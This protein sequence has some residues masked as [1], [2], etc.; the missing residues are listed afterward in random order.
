MAGRQYLKKRVRGT[1]LSL[2]FQAKGDLAQ[3]YSEMADWANRTPRETKKGQELDKCC[4]ELW[5]IKW[6]H[7]PDLAGVVEW[8]IVSAEIIDYR[9]RQGKKL[10]RWKRAETIGALI[11]VA[12]L[13]VAK[14]EESI[15]GILEALNEDEEASLDEIATKGAWYEELGTKCWELIPELEQLSKDIEGI[16]FPGLR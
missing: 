3:L 15:D 13:S 5:R 8:P 6:P 9:P 7:L 1:A 10:Q 2:M 11:G 12:S 16:N 14:L 4:T